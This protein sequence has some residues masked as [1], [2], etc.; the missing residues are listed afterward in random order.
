MATGL[1]VLARG[2]PAVRNLFAAPRAVPGRW[3]A[4]PALAVVGVLAAVT[5]LLVLGGSG[6]WQDGRFDHRRPGR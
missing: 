3:L 6:D 4:G 5:A 1:H 2:L